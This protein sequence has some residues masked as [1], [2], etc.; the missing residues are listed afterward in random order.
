LVAIVVALAIA[1]SVADRL[2]VS[3]ASAERLGGDQ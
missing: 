3:R 2:V 1:V